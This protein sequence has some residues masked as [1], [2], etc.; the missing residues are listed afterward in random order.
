MVESMEISII[1][2][3]NIVLDNLEQTVIEFVSIAEVLRKAKNNVDCSLIFDNRIGHCYKA[4][5]VK[6]VRFAR[7]TEGI[8]IIN[9]N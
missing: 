8:S 7:E 5:S 6:D 4:N 9:L 3:K 2:N 1:L